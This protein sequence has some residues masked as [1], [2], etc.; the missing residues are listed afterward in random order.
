MDSD[1]VARASARLGTVL[2]GK[3][4]LERVLGAGGMAVVYVATHRNNK[5]FAV[6]MLHPELSLREDIRT[7]F[8]REGYAANSVKHPG[9]VAVLDDDTAED[10]A[11]FLVMELLEGAEVEKLWEER[12]Q[13]LPAPQVLGIA[14]Q[15]LDIL[16]EAHARGIVHRDIKPANLFVT[17][18]GQLKVLDFG[19][20][21]VRDLVASSAQ[22]T[23]TGMLLGTPA[24]M[25]PEQALAK[26]SQIDAL[27]DVWAVGAT[28]FTLLTGRTVHEGE[29]GPEIFVKAATQKAPSLAAVDPGAPSALVG[30]VDR[31]LAFE[32]S[33]RWGSAAEMR[34]AAAEA[35]AALE[36][37]R[38]SRESLLPLVQVGRGVRVTNEHVD[39]LASTPAPQMAIPPTVDAAP[40]VAR[41]AAGTLGTPGAMP[42]PGPSV[43]AYSIFE[44]DVSS[45]LPDA[46]PAEALRPVAPK[47]PALPEEDVTRRMTLAEIRAQAQRPRPIVGGTTSQPVSSGQEPI[48]PAGVP[49]KVGRWPIVVAA[50]ILL[51]V[52]GAAALLREPSKVAATPAPD[53]TLPPPPTPTILPSA[54]DA[55]RAPIA[56]SDG[57]SPTTTAGTGSGW[58]LVTPLPP[59]PPFSP[60]TSQVAKD[61]PLDHPSQPH[62]P[63]RP[64]DRAAVA[65]ALGGV[66]VGSCS[67]PGGPTGQGHLSMTFLPDGSVDRVTVDQPPYQGTAE[68][69]CVA[70]K[71]RTLRVPPFDEGPQK[72]SKAFVLSPSTQVSPQ[73]SCRPVFDHYD[74][75]WQPVYR[76]DCQ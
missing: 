23:G 3:Y 1:L 74:P 14:H 68:G 33:A 8:L 26:A 30:V 35:Y 52:S 63:L 44:S 65:A 18:E 53:P 49:K 41:G 32:K 46:P 71:F 13:R 75:N 72:V 55:G 42:P 6:K 11:A 39:A 9:A 19:I 37:R 17:T 27:T 58:Q 38:V 25:S 12:G 43:L 40:V 28:M 21:R 15:L 69:A 62:V 4:R 22:A 59:V 70:E 54:Q 73:P 45:V 20:A 31:A 76:K 67:I 64:F 61:H 66:D 36:A 47:A 48:E 29:T 24:F 10:G 7:R 16:V 50:G 2:R 51:C 60:S 57:G 34:D 5:Q 56:V